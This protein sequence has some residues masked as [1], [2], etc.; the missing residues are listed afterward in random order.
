MRNSTYRIQSIF[1]E[2]ADEEHT[3]RIQSIFIESADEEHTY[4]IQSIFIESA[5]EEH[6]YRFQSIFIES[7]DE[8]DTYRIQS[9]FIESADEEHT[10]RFQSIF[11]E[12]A[13]EEDTY[14]IQS[15]F[16]E[17]ADEEQHVPARRMQHGFRRASDQRQVVEQ[18]AA[19][20]EV[21]HVEGFQKWLAKQKRMRLMQGSNWNLIAFTSPFVS[22]RLKGRFT[23]RPQFIVANRL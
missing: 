13:D 23:R 11:I 8:E 1:I 15:I 4:R 9:I 22:G 7:A 12:S 14:R 19:R 20:C 5:D 18:F 17:S 21:M 2:S 3:Y 10:Y 6:T 16:I